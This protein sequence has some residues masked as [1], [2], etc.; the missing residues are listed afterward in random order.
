MAL[1]WA[2]PERIENSLLTEREPVSA[3]VRFLA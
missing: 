2:D 3:F 1:G